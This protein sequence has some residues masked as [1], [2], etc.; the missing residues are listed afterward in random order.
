[1]K[2]AL[3]I[4]GILFSF[5]LAANAKYKVGE[6]YDKDG[7]KGMVVVVDESGEHG[8]LLSLRGSDNRWCKGD[9]K[10]AVNAISEDDGAQNMAAVEKYINKKNL[11]WNLFPLF[12]WAKEEL[13]EGWYIPSKNELLAVAESLNGGSL[14][15]Y[16]QKSW[17][18]FDKIIKKAK[19]KGLILNGFAQANDFL[20]MDSSTETAGNMIYTLE[21]AESSGSK[22][23][24]FAFGKLAGRKGKLVMKAG[25]KTFN[26]GKMANHYSRAVYKF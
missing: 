25:L 5:I 17:K 10:T 11:S 12:K 2:K 9:V 3:F 20:T 4:I 6:I 22:L 21:F 8:L 19:G 15:K 24:N 1:M 18:N 7:V 14:D 16:N 26:G 13:G 23:S